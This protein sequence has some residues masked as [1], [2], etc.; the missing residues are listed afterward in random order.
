MKNTRLYRSKKVLDVAKPMVLTRILCH[1]GGWICWMEWKN[2]K[3]SNKILYTID[4]VRYLHF[5]RYTLFVPLPSK[6]VVKGTHGKRKLNH[7][8]GSTTSPNCQIYYTGAMK[9]D[10]VQNKNTP[11]S[12]WKTALTA[13]TTEH[14]H[15][16]GSF[17][18]KIIGRLWIGFVIVH[19]WST[20][21]IWWTLA[22]IKMISKSSHTWLHCSGR[23]IKDSNGFV[24]QHG[25]LFLTWVSRNSEIE[26]GFVGNGS[27]IDETNVKCAGEGGFD[28]HVWV[29]V[30]RVD[31]NETTGFVAC[32]CAVCAFYDDMKD[33]MLDLARG[34][35]S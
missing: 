6:Y 35:L 8:V 31:M 14:T 34:Y 19:I 2:I 11:N 15:D 24:D 22:G 9:H 4:A 3:S 7:F 5:Q 10:I 1:Y 26:L 18:G 32:C 27:S 25:F 20:E 33:R 17:S 16:T 23:L 29:L 12:R 30:L 21:Q 28:G 13:S